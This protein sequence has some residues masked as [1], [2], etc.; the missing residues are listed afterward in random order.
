[1]IMPS[2]SLVPGYIQIKNT[3]KLNCTYSRIAKK[4]KLTKQ[5]AGE[6]VE[7]LDFIH[8]VGGINTGK[9]FWQ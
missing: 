9:Y 5:S 1:M 7:E 2:L 3:M 8:I 4:K 6:Y